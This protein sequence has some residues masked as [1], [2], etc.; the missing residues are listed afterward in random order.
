MNKLRYEGLPETVRYAADEWQGP[1]TGAEGSTYWLNTRTQER[2]YQPNKPESRGDG[3]QEQPQAQQGQQGPTE[4]QTKA[5]AAGYAQKARE[6]FGDQ[7]HEKLS[8]IAA[9]LE[10][11]AS[12]EAQRKLGAVKAMLESLGEQQPQVDTIKAQAE[13]LKQQHGDD[14]HEQLDGMI[15]DHDGGLDPQAAKKQQQLGQVKAALGPEAQHKV[16]AR[17]AAKL[18]PE[19]AKAIRDQQWKNTPRADDWA[20]WEQWDKEKVARRE[21]EDAAFSARREEIETRHTVEMEQAEAAVDAIGERR[22]ELAE[23]R[24]K[25]DEDF[26]TAADEEDEQARTAWEAESEQIE[27]GRD[28]EDAKS[29]A[30]REAVRSSIME[31]F[32]EEGDSWT[33]E[34]QDAAQ[35]KLDKVEAKWTKEDDR[36]YDRRA[37]EDVK[38]EEAWDKTQEKREARREKEELKREKAREKEDEKLDKEEEK[39]DEYKSKLED[40]HAEEID[41]FD[42]EVDELDSARQEED[43]SDEESQASEAELRDSE[44]EEEEGRAVALIDSFVEVEDGE[45]GPSPEE[46]LDAVRAYNEKAAKSGERK[47]IT[48]HQGQMFKG[49]QVMDIDDL[50]DDDVAMF[51]PHAS[52]DPEPQQYSAD[53]AHTK[54]PITPRKRLR[55]AKAKPGAKGRTKR[56]YKVPAWASMRAR[57]AKPD[58]PLRIETKQ[59]LRQPWDYDA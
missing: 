43:E 50:S 38:R 31:L 26:Q 58:E 10:G 17:Q 24:E 55:K 2:R 4:E 47:R 45:S 49:W 52:S 56:S 15:N 35:E 32:P 37:A 7:A 5:K 33:Q 34:A 36:D 22:D 48:W 27:A 14:A 12:P 44:E 8:A 23:A 19:A 59:L 46:Q 29:E 13:Q 18:T 54:G 25:E 51:I 1:N 42:T 11:D 39:L 30:E 6:Q 20:R 21:Q 3:Q 41:E 53:F 57:Y 28:E 16:N 40:K 9:K